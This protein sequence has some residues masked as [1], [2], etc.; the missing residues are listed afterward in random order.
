MAVKNV[1]ALLSQTLRAQVPA[2]QLPITLKKTPIGNLYE[3]LSRTPSAGVGLQVHQTRWGT[4]EIHGSY[5]VVSRAQF[6]REG[7]N[8]KAWGRLY[9]KGKLVSEKEERIRGCLKYNWME[10]PSIAK[11]IRLKE[12]ASEASTEATPSTA[13]T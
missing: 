6:K 12:I 3:I 11:S 4:K 1:T 9:W 10:G 2:S 5:W 8:G 13:S 7:K